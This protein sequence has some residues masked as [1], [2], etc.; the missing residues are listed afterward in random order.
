VGWRKKKR[1]EID[2]SQRLWSL[3]FFVSIPVFYGLFAVSVKTAWDA[4]EIRGVDSVQVALFVH[5]FIFALVIL[6]SRRLERLRTFLHELKH[7]AAIIV[8]GGTLTGFHSGRD[9]GYV[10]YKITKSGRRFEPFVGLAPYFL[11]LLS[12]PVLAVCVFLEGNW[13]YGGLYVL[14]FAFAAD[15][16]TAYE[17]LR[18]PQVDLVIIWGGY[19]TTRL[20]IIGANLCWS[21]LIAIWLLAGREGYLYAALLLIRYGG[22]LVGIEFA[23]QIF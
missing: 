5:G 8:T 18:R 13:K 17:E 20:F 12:G 22:S 3:P 6:A 19:I 9:T 1:P 16:I 11:P 15:I 21:G 23:L 7:A 2:L 14:S 4:I 10:E